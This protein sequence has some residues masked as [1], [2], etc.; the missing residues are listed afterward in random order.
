MRNQ[1]FV[2][3]GKTSLRYATYLTF[4]SAREANVVSL[5]FMEQRKNVLRKSRVGV[6][7]A[8]F[9]WHFKSCLICEQTKKPFSYN[10]MGDKL[11]LNFE[12]KFQR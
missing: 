5:F 3:F 7:N 1:L 6:A 2:H 10:I 4:F 8:I 12:A 9:K 11:L